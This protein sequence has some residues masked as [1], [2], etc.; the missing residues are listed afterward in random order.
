MK[1]KLLLIV[2][3][4]FIT[5]AYS[6]ITPTY[7]KSLPNGEITVNGNLESG[8]KISDLSWAWN[9][10][11][12][13]FPA[14]QQNSFNGNHVLY[15]TTLPKKSILEIT[16]KPKN[17]SAKMSIYGYSVGTNSNAVVPNLSSCVS[18]EVD[19]NQMGKATN[20]SR[21]IRLNA[22]NNPY[23]VY[24][25]VVGENGLQKG[26]YT[27]TIKLTGGESTK[28]QE[29][30]PLPQNVNAIPNGEVKIEGSIDNGVII[31]DLSWAWNSSNACF[32]AT[33]QKSFN[34]NHVLYETQLPPHAILEITLTP[35]NKNSKMSLY[36]YQIGTKSNY[37]VPNLPTCVSC[38]ADNN[39]M[40]KATT[41]SRTI[42]FNAIKNPYKVVFGV[43]GEN[44]L[45]TGDFSI[46]VKMKG[47]EN[48]P[49]ATQN[50][51]IVKSCKAPEKGNILA[52]KDDIKN[53]VLIHD[54]SWAWN[55]SVACFPETQKQS[56][57]GKHVLFET[58]IPKYSEMTITLIPTDK[59]AKLS[60]YGYQIGTT[61]NYV[62]PNLPSCVSC[63]ADNNQMGKATN[64]QRSI[65][66]M[67][68]NHPY[69]IMIGVAGVKGLTEGEFVIKISLKGR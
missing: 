64:N 68:I 56:F 26:D 46:T 41:N 62:V 11:V 38:E 20:N 49:L 3:L 39:Q 23:K 25:G 7:I 47:G 29:A 63:E 69:K 22:I 32:P 50:K 10:S 42:T 12:A 9:S 14:T 37:V 6:Q 8:A 2:S 36:G 54:L 40:G 5:S 15:E 61:S 1:S 21:T 58:S 53:G 66:F 28:V 60:L 43:V 57:T 19:N 31:H 48:K 18:C 33:Q 45:L 59:K 27:I 65:K 67:A 16:L 52:Y 35:K 17:P 44:K 13:C 30:V 34:G 24:F 51:V 4:L 55:S